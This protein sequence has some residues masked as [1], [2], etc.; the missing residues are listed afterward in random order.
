MCLFLV[1]TKD[2]N[3]RLLVPSYEDSTGS[4]ENFVILKSIYWQR[5]LKKTCYEIDFFTD[6]KLILD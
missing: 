5:K 4:R 1:V 3:P 6:P 2:A